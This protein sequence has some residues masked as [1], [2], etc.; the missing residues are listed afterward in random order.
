MTSLSLFTF[1]HWR[2]K[3][4]PTP[5]FLL[6]ESQGQQSLVGCRLWGRTESDRLKRLSSTPLFETLQRSPLA[7]TITSKLLHLSYNV[8]TDLYLNFQLS[9]I[10]PHTKQTKKALLPPPSPPPS[11]GLTVY[12]NAMHLPHS[13]WKITFISQSSAQVLPLL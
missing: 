1:M 2:R 12:L 5:V 9:A 4:Q 11:T 13:T 7:A 10:L 6:G 3:W 8:F